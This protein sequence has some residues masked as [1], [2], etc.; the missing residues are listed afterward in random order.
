[1]ASS[2]PLGTTKHFTA[3]ILALVFTL[4]SSDLCAAVTTQIRVQVKQSEFDTS[5][6]Y[7]T[8]L[9]T[10]ALSKQKIIENW[11]LTEQG[12]HMTQERGLHQLKSNASYDVY[13]AGTSR[14]REEDLQAI[15][16]P[17]TK[18]LLG[19]RV[20]LVHKDNIEKLNQAK[21]RAKILE[22]T[23]CQA[24]HWP[25]TEILTAAGFKV[26]KS[27]AYEGLFKQ[28][29]AKR[30]DFFPRS[31]AEAESEFQARK[32]AY[33]DIR[34]H[35]SL[36]I[37]YP[38]PMYFFVNRKRQL[39]AKSIAAGLEKAID[40]GSFDTLMEQHETTRHLFPLDNWL[41]ARYLRLKNSTLPI[42]TDTTNARYWVQPPENAVVIH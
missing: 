35:K 16:I 27:P 14:S 1:M 24:P 39:L 8:E 3:S 11:D 42:D 5:H 22:L 15:R 38:F 19:F 31:V 4:I 7:F 28:L 36:I 21:S 12:I 17:L 6:D 23:P 41:N 34:L 40:D 9:L 33:P 20:S 2:R 25:D 18:G 10:L 26:I 30:C 37:H 13:W 32:S 29:R